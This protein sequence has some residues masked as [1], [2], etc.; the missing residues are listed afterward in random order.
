M[1]REVK[2]IECRV[3]GLVQGVFYRAYVSERAAARGIV[4]K[5]ENLREGSVLVVAEGPEDE[6]RFFAEELSRGPRGAKVE[7]VSV[8]WQEAAGEYNDFSIQ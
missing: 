7:S 5:A 2:R 1:H 4:G 6:L 8:S 3:L